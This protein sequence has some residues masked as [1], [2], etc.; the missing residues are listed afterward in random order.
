[1]WRVAGSEMGGTIKDFT[2]LLLKS[3][4]STPSPRLN[5]HSTHSQP[6]R[7]SSS[8]PHPAA[9]LTRTANQY[10]TLIHPPHTRDTTPFPHQHHTTTLLAFR[11]VELTTLP[12]QYTDEVAVTV[13]PVVATLTTVPTTGTTLTVT[14]V[15][16]IA[17]PPDT[18]PTPMYAF[19]SH[20]YLLTALADLDGKF[21]HGAY[22]YQ[23]GATTSPRSNYYRSSPS[24]GER[25]LSFFGLGSGSRY[26]D[27]YGRPIDSRGRSKYK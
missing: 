13:A 9:A 3:H 6:C 17:L 1:M 22:R 23:T 11:V 4:P 15:V 24:L 25:I 20:S 21:Q 27:R 10:R 16:P 19:L 18:V 12:P 7:R 5:F 8:H 26:V 2:R 14:I